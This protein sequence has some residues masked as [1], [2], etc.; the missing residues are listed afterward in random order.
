MIENLK[1]EK[2]QKDIEE[3]NLT[4]ESQNDDIATL[5]KELDKTR[6]SKKDVSDV[7]IEKKTDVKKYKKRQKIFKIPMP[8]SGKFLNKF[9]NAYISTMKESDDFHVTIKNDELIFDSLEWIL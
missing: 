8:V 4:L 5:F 6:K 3:I 9:L 1:I 2:I 7:V